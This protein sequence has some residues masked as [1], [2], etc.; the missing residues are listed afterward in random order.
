MEKELAAVYRELHCIIVRPRNAVGIDPD[1]V[2][3]RLEH[4][5]FVNALATMGINK[6]VAKQHERASG[7]SPTILRRRLSKIP[8]IRVPR[9][10]EEEATARRLIPFALAGV[11][12]AASEVD[13]GVVS[14]LAG[15]D[16]DEIEANICQ[17]L[18]L[19]DSPVW[20][21]GQHRGVTSKLDCSV[22]DW[23]ADHR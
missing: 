23:Q 3:D 15:E 4:G 2:A 13:R 20:S 19:D 22:R 17:L 1:V 7:R 8:A 21:T 16:Y 18:R 12:D 9:W 14:T 5:S 6:D 11:W 10:A